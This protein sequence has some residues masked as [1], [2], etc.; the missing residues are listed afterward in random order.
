MC[1]VCFR[2]G[3]LYEID[4]ISTLCIRKLKGHSTS[5]NKVQ[6]GANRM[7]TVSDDQTVCIWY[8]K[9][10]TSQ[11]C[12]YNLSVTCVVSGLSGIASTKFTGH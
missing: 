3:L 1:N 9:T 7:V 6:A 8:K 5:V 12:S 2:N 4:V 10:V 11:V